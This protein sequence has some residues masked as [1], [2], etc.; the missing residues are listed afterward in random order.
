[1]R[2]FTFLFLLGVR[3]WWWLT[4]LSRAGTVAQAGKEAEKKREMA[5]S[6]PVHRFADQSKG[7]EMRW[8]D[9]VFR[10]SRRRVHYSWWRTVVAPCAF[11][12]LCVF[13]RSPGRT[14]CAAGEY[15]GD[16]VAR[17]REAE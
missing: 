7:D 3:I 9:S 17:L 16:K 13:G 10:E 14:L 6:A 1:M 15:G 12:A 8:A 5:T 11:Y 2:K 4:E